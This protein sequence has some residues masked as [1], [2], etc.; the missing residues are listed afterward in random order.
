ML[1]RTRLK[2]HQARGLALLAIFCCSML[3]RAQAAPEAQVPGATRV[4]QWKDDKKAAFLLMFDDGWPS[5]WQVAAPELV[6]RGMI[7]TFYIVPNK[8][9]F[10]K[11]EKTWKEDLLKQGMVYG[12]HTMTHDGLQ[13]LEDA[14]WEYGEC[15]RYIK[16]LTPGKE[17]RLVSFGKPGVTDWKI[18]PEQEKELLAK[19]H[20]IDRPDFRGHG[21][22][23][24]LKTTEEMLALADKAIAQ[25][26]LEYLVIH[27]V[28][29]IVPNWGYQDFWALKQDIFLPL[30]DGLAA[31]REKGDL[32][33]TDHISAH[34]YETERQ[35]ATVKVLEAN[36]QK[37]RLELKSQAD[38]H[39]YDLPLTLVTHVPAAWGQCEVIQGEK[40][41]VVAAANG[42]LRFE[43]LP[44]GEP[45]TITS[46]TKKPSARKAPPFIMI[47]VDDLKSVRGKVHPLW[48]KLVDFLK[49]R[50]IKAG[51][52]IICDSLEGDSPEYFKWI[53]DQQAS[54][55]IEFWNHGYDHKEWTEGDKKLQEFKGTSYEHQKQH[56]TRANQLAREKLG[57]P[58]QSFGAPFNA[59]DQNTVKAL[60]EDPDI[61]IWLYGDL[62]NPGGKI[63]LDRVGSVNIENPTFLPSLEKF[64]AGYA[65]YPDREFFVI[66]GHPA[67]WTEE[68]FQQFVKIIDFLTAEK[69]VF[70]TPS[71]YVRDKKLTPTPSAP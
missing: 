5:H 65:K 63:V 8:G 69:A 51:I 67:H 53:R 49:E 42:T 23:Y 22:V 26:G 66:Q 44:G 30:L 32:W 35:T 19:N 17:P 36:A 68:R 2:G 70:T 33:I 18:T 21:A 59:T 58:F 54:G 29:R 62:K 14:E 48:K 7:A 3:C 43:A 61:K 1:G 46:G 38:P 31:R 34:K 45:V 47:K 20:L 40:K 41:T 57:F 11:F 37:I 55:L 64:M 4:A 50:K 12:N 15:T 9:E 24:H 39:L 13:S 16:S 6:K 27:G 60:A 10:K 52:G 25:G 71:D 28:E 56:L